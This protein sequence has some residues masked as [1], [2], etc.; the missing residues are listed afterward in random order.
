MFNQT[1]AKRPEAKNVGTVWSGLSTSVG[2]LVV[3]VTKARR[4]VETYIV[5]TRTFFISNRIPSIV[6]SRD[7]RHAD[8]VRSV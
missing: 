8:P 3:F 5:P 6:N 7:T 2:T 1:R 4:F